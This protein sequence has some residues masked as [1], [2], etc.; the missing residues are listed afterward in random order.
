VGKYRERVWW[1]EFKRVEEAH[2][3]FELCYEEIVEL[4][5]KTEKAWTGR[6]PT[7]LSG[8]FPKKLR[9]PL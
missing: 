6:I 4:V 1:R 8:L 2:R 7:P 9:P 5:P 3:F